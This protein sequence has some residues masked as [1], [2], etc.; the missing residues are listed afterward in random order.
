MIGIKNLH[1]FYN[2]GRPNELH[3]IN[4][5]S[6]E[7]PEKGLVAVFGKSGCGKTTL[8]NVIGGLDGF[9]EG[10]VTID[11]RD[12]RNGTDEIRNAYIGYIF[13]NYNLNRS[14]TC[15]D[16]VADALRLCGMT[17]TA[18][19]ESRVEAAL[20]NVGMEKYG[21]RLPD[22]LSGGQQQRIAIARAIVKNPRIILADEP[23]G[24]LDEANTVMIMDL[25]RAI[26][27]DHL[28]LLVT[29]EAELVDHY[30]DRVIELSDGRVVGERENE[31]AT[32]LSAKDKNHIFLGDLPK[33]ESSDSRVAVEYYGDEPASPIRLRVVNHGGSLYLEVESGGVKLLDQSSEVKLREGCYEP[34]Q[35]QA[36]SERKID[37]S[38]I[39]PVEG[40]RFGRLFSLRSALVSG[41]KANFK[42][43]KRGSKLLRRSL[44]IFA[45]ATVFMSAVFGTSIGNLS[46]IGDSYNHNVFYVYTDTPETSEKLLGTPADVS[47]IDSVR[48][49]SYHASGDDYAYFHVGSF[50][51]FNGIGVVS[52]FGTN[53][54][55]LDASLVE[56][57]EL[58]AGR[59]EG[60]ADEEVLISQ[61]VA[62]SLLEKSALGYMNEY[63]DL[64]GLLSWSEIVDGKSLRVAGVVKSDEPAIYASELALTKMLFDRTPMSSS[65]TASSFGIDVNAGET[66]L[67]IG[68]KQSSAPYPGI[69]GEVL[70]QGKYYKVADVIERQGHYDAYLASRGI[71]KLG[72]EEYFREMLLA[73]KPQLSENTDE[74]NLA[75]AE[76]TEQRYFEYFDYYYLQIGEFMSSL[77][78]FGEFGGWLYTEKNIH[79]A[80][81]AYLSEDY[82]VAKAYKEQHGRYPT[83]LEY[84]EL[85]GSSDLKFEYVTDAFYNLYSDEFYQQHR[86]TLFPA[87]YLLSDGDFASLGRGM[88]ENDPTARTGEGKMGLYTVVHSVD[89]EKTAAWLESEFGEL[90]NDYYE[91]LHTP[92]SIFEELIREQKV[93][94]T[95]SLV[96]LGVLIA[97]MCACMY[98]IMRSSLMNRIKEVGILRAIG[99]SKKNLVFRFF[100][101]SAVLFALTVFIGF[102]ATTA[103]IASATEASEL[104]S[105]VMYYPGWLA[106]CVFALLFG[107]S[108]LFGILPILSLLRKTPS[109][110]LSKYDI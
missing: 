97:I 71:E 73:E 82:R 49:K 46:E 34:R 54:V 15:F 105:E 110:I 7:L 95:A 39:P 28:V 1:K 94:I 83:R 74:F 37:M 80:A 44:G 25:L 109:E 70:I 63:S 22:T 92:D 43:S 87:T 86:P 33:H 61:R 36:H 66:V 101:E 41:Y 40:R 30:C 4:D 102:V 45:A 58:L 75:L 103:F 76:L 77:C 93:E 56:G 12:V 26:A 52:D 19:I 9:V 85:R 64:L 59:R 53:A 98:F 13:Q 8:L 29:H 11:G 69:G 88:G 38:A 107:V 5:V 2:K 35:G 100:V 55:Y 3:V 16:N 18:E 90:T 81:D 106:A 27:N 50:E 57:S 32:G 72:G 47:G 60:L 14:E 62:D 104:M 6:L 42:K 23:T 48:L 84:E 21:K 24:N 65:S 31:N 78:L 96:G 51:S 91:I 67:L 17:D 99:V 108:I 10:S 79:E 89:P 68:M 20:A